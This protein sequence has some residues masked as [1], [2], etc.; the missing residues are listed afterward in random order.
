MFSFQHV[1]ITSHW[2]KLLDK[3]TV[4]PLMS[5]WNQFLIL[6]L[7]NTTLSQCFKGC[8]IFQRAY[9]LICLRTLKFT[10]KKSNIF[11]DRIFFCSRFCHFPLL[12]VYGKAEW[13]CIQF[14]IAAEII[15]MSFLNVTVASFRQQC[16][17]WTFVWQFSFFILKFS[18]ANFRT[19]THTSFFKHYS[20]SLNTDID[21]ISFISVY[22]RSILLTLATN[23]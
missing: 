21:C 22:I 17:F 13:Q 8:N 20:V 9:R 1:W 16:V 14:Q 3:I 12:F 5:F 19:L 10:L 11:R 23:I 6:I 2:I 7:L 15:D 18:L 4:I